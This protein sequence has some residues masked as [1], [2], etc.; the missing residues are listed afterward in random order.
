MALLLFMWLNTALL[1]VL[2][3]QANNISILT[4]PLSSV[5]NKGFGFYSLCLGMFR[6]SYSLDPL[7][8]SVQNRVHKSLS[9]HWSESQSSLTYLFFLPVYAGRKA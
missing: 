3:L 7:P 8:V 5:G 1:T 9:I 2:A 4:I 6:H